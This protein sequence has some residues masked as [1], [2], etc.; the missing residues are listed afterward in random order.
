MSNT[1]SLASS[2]DA[3]MLE[4]KECLKYMRDGHW[5]EALTYAQ[6]ALEN[7]PQNP[8]Y[9][10]YTGLLAALAQ[11]RALN[12]ERLCKEAVAIKHNHAQLYLNLAQVYLQAGRTTDAIATL[13][14]GLVSTGRDVRIRRELKK[15]GLRREPVLSF[16]ERSHPLNRTLGKV[17]HR[18]M[19]ASKTTH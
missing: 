7:G 12:A 9:L 3:G 16:L 11:N 4:F 6:R 10:S 17:R 8:F 18:L 1:V 15:L 19:G 2:S 14:K 5:D 13:E